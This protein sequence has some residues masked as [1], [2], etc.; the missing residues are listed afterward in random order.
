MVSTFS[1]NKLKVLCFVFNL[2]VSFISISPE[3]TIFPD[4]SNT[5]LL[6]RFNRLG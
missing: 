3:T 6:L 5:V 2:P 1:V 4:I